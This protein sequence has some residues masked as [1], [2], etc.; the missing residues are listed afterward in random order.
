MT[1]SS[2]DDA[3]WTAG[4]ER[5]W[6]KF[7]PEGV[8]IGT[9]RRMSPADLVRLV[10]EH[11]WTVKMILR[12]LDQRPRPPDPAAGEAL[13]RAHREGRVGGWVTAVLLH[14][15]RVDGRYEV[16][17]DILRRARNLIEGPEA[18]GVMAAQDPASACAVFLEVL[19]DETARSLPRRCVAIALRGM[20]DPRI[21]PTVIEAVRDGRL[22]PV[23]GASAIDADTLDADAIIGWLGASDRAVATFASELVRRRLAFDDS[24]ARAVRCAVEAGRIEAIDGERAISERQRP[25]SRVWSATQRKGG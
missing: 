17:A 5:L 21:V 4:E 16:A 2:D 9:L 8:P 19:L 12:E 23:R 20:R 18:A 7:G 25:P 14:P 22:G 24:I 3:S 6:G 15:L 11:N 1:P 13:V 10:V